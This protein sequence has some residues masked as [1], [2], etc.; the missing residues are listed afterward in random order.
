MNCASDPPPVKKTVASAVPTVEEANE[1]LARVTYSGGPS[2]Y[3]PYTY[4]VDESQFNSWALT[5]LP[6]VIKYV[7][8]FAKT[9][10]S[11]YILEIKGHADSAKGRV[12]NST[13]ATRRAKSFYDRLIK[14]KVP[15]EKLKY[16]GASA[17]EP[18]P[19]IEADARAQRRVTFRL[20]PKS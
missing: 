7:D 13:L 14:A 3:E 20:I 19:G 10:D 5:N 12:S 17:N 8:S 1:A 9:A 11:K 16:V 4:A 2:G 18:I 15:K 6:T